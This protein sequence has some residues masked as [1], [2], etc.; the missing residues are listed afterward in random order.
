MLAMVGGLNV[1]LLG[2]H[3]GRCRGRRR[4]FQANDLPVCSSDL[5]LTH[6]FEVKHPLP[7]GNLKLML[8]GLVRL[9]KQPAVLV[10]KIVEFGAVVALPPPE[11]LRGRGQPSRCSG[12]GIWL[13]RC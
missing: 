2:L 4:T 13:D 1:G 11:H 12:A 5:V 3:G 10:R 6:F 8:P 9:L 7:F